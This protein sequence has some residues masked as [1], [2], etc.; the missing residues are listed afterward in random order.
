MMIASFAIHSYTY[1]SMFPLNFNW[2][3]QNIVIQA[4]IFVDILVRGGNFQ[5]W[6]TRS[7][8]KYETFSKLWT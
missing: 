4:N 3:E 2:E 1:E 8:Q 5:R 7:Q 6:E